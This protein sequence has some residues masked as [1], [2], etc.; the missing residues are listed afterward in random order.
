MIAFASASTACRPSIP[1]V[2]EPAPARGG[3]NSISVSCA[4]YGKVT[5]AG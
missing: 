2:H 1:L 4:T 3:L 5:R